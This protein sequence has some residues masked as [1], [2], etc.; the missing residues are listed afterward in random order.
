MRGNNILGILFAYVNDERVPN[1]TRSRVMASVPFGGRY[2]LVDFTLS[3]MVNSGIN[4]VGVITERNYQSLMDHLGSGK[5]WDLSRKREGLFLLP[6]FDA[7]HSRTD[8][9]VE[10]LDSIKRFI[11][12]SQ[13]EYVMLSDTDAIYNMNYKEVLSYHIDKKSDLT[14]VYRHGTNPT[15]VRTGVLT[16]NEED[17][18]TNY[19]IFDKGANDSDI[20]MGVYIIKKEK[21]LDLIETCISENILDFDR[22]VM[23]KCV[24]EM[25]VY[26]Y[27]F[28]GKYYQITGRGEYFKANMALMDEEVRKEL[29]NPQRPIYT[30]VRD[31]M[32]AKY[33]LASH[34]TNSIVADGCAIEGEVD[35]CVLFRGVKIGKG[36]VLKNCVIMQ[37]S[38]IGENVKMTKIISDKDV[39]VKDNAEIKGA[40]SYAMYLKKGT[41][42]E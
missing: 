34:V 3:N 10:S 11:E 29:F 42:I 20:N 38:V 5:A 16:L 40:E 17:Q 7:D 31:D 14:V 23:F 21:L 28:T 35:G 8:G 25:K 12:N 13:E 2:R 27:E 37:D 4:K 19:K 32:P 26:A 9:K 22:S 36:S 6:P 41:V 15:H 1:L 33:G 18:V 24:K 30:K 39:I